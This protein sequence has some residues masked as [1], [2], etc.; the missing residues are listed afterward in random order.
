MSRNETY[1]NLS[2]SN[3][4]YYS[5]PIQE[6]YEDYL[7]LDRSI[8]ISI[9][10][11]NK[12]SR[13]KTEISD[14]YLNQ[15]ED[16]EI[17]INFDDNID[18]EALSEILDEIEENRQINEKK[19]KTRNNKKKSSSVFK[20]KRSLHPSQKNKKEK[21]RSNISYDKRLKEIKRANTISEL[22]F[23]YKELDDI[24]SKYPFFEIAQIILKINNDINDEDNNNKELY[25]KIK[26]ITSII[27]D[28]NNITLMCLSILSSKSLLN[29]HINQIEESFIEINDIEE[30]E[31]EKNEE[32]IK[33][34]DGKKDNDV[35]KAKAERKGKNMEKEINENNFFKG[36]KFKKNKYLFGKHFY[37]YKENIYCYV[38]KT[39]KPSRFVSVYCLHRYQGCKA[40]I[41]VYRNSDYVSVIG[42][43][44]HRSRSSTEFYKKY[45]FLKNVEWKH[46]QIIKEGGKELVVL[47]K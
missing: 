46:I 29:D 19:R 21:F 34:E 32:D 25:E 44:K 7:N 38:P 47:Q 9:D 2:Q 11:S 17:F 16:E 40:K 33:I 30:I 42:T 36:F 39:I 24:I 20:R 18:E 14:L 28:K 31:K 8:T 5:S 41:I 43:H 27:K 22:N 23:C 12:K 15:N 1:I 45:P 4:Y 35:T 13:T 10:S 26:K 37:K 6:G 3:E